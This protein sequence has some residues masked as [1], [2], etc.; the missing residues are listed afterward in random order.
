MNIK[1]L[2]LALAT[3]AALGTS[4]GAQA[5]VTVKAVTPV[6]TE[7]Q[8]SSLMAAALGDD[9]SVSAEGLPKCYKKLSKNWKS[10]VRC[11]C[12]FEPSNSICPPSNS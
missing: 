11:V 3:V 2:A 1:Q 9:D 5:V 7:V 6:A 8:S 10:Y 12:K 4:V